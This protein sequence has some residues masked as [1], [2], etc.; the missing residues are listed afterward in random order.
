MFVLLTSSLIKL[1]N[2]KD[3]RVY[4]Y[5][6]RTAGQTAG[7]I[8]LTF[9]VAKKSIFFHFFT[10]FKSFFFHEQHRALQLVKL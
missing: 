3:I 7:P 5:M 2:K 4:I 8:G 9:F 1:Y 6:L 10:F